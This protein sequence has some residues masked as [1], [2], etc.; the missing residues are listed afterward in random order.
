MRSVLVDLYLEDPYVLIQGLVFSLVLVKTS[1]YYERVFLELLFSPLLLFLLSP[2]R[3]NILHK[4]E[5]VQGSLCPYPEVSAVGRYCSAPPL[6]NFRKTMT[7]RR[8]E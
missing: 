6:P 2:F 5:I 3:L 4:F 7:D 1:R 8:S